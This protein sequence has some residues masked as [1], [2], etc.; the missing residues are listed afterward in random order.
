MPDIMAH[1]RRLA[2][3]SH[4]SHSP[5]EDPPTMVSM[6]HATQGWAAVEVRRARE[7]WRSRAL[8]SSIRAGMSLLL[9]AVSAAFRYRSARMERQL[10][11]GMPDL[12]ANRGCAR[13]A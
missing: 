10:R 5:G 9:I 7:T 1:S 12:V 3:T 8:S 2:A 4:F 11:P 6:D 13:G